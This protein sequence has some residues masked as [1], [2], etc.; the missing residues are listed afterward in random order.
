MSV[1]IVEPHIDLF[2]S[3][4]YS[5]F[6]MSMSTLHFLLIVIVYLLKLPFPVVQ[7]DFF[8]NL[9]AVFKICEELENVDGLHMILNIVKGIS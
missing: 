3:F 8:R 1:D 4:G 6:V 2:S 5:K 9:M 7:N